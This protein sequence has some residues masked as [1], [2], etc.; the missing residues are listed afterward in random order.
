MAKLSEVHKALA[1]RLTEPVVRFLSRTPITPS[2]ITWFGFL[3]T[4]GAAALIITGHLL[5]AG[6]VV[7]IAGFFDM[8]DG[9]LARR[10]NQATRFGAVLDSTLDRLSEAV[11]LLGILVHYA[12]EQSTTGILLVGAALIGSLLVSY[13]RARAEALGLECQMGLFTRFE[14]VI[15][16]V[17][18]LLLN[19]IDNA[20][21]IALAI[22]AAFSFFT[23]G[24][25]LV[26]VWRQTK[27][28]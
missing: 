10:T 4:A 18:G 22:I 8:L 21:I 26:Y 17:L 3:L 28:S 25:R 16:L 13:I 19:Q 12:G 6:F 11:L 24:Q 14:R 7:L 20:L 15:V 27:N 2:A 1:Y 5:V 23:A 9:A